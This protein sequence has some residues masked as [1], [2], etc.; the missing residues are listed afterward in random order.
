MGKIS[1]SFALSLTLIF[2]ISR[3]TRLIIKPANAQAGVTNPP[4]PFFEVTIESPLSGET[5]TGTM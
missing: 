2:T 5:I 1:K 3:L 4:I